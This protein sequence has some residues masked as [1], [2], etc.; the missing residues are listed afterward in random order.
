MDRAKRHVGGPVSQGR[1]VESQPL[2][3]ISA[4]LTPRQRQTH[5]L[6]EVA[7]PTASAPTPPSEPRTCGA[8]TVV[9]SGVA[10]VLTSSCLILFNKSALSTY[11]FG[12]PNALLCFHCVL[13]V[14]LVKFC[15]LLGYIRLEP[16]R[17][18]VVKLWL[19]VNLIF[20]GMIATS[21]LALKLI[22]VGEGLH[23][24]SECS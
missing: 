8:S 5:D 10:Y 17:W 9:V 15:E 16:I 21:F 19:P 1:D 7:S 20:V 13:A 4:K 22:G 2:L 24:S 14:V 18:N 23:E 12:C 3:P 11:N 6:V